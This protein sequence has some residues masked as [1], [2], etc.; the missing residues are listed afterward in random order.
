MGIFSGL[1]SKLQKSAT[2]SL[3]ADQIYE[4]LKVVIDPDLGK[5]IVTL[6]FVRNP[7]IE[8]QNV[9]VEV[10]LTTPACP[11]KEQLKTQCENALKALPGIG[12]VT[13]TMTATTREP[14]RDA[15]AKVHPALAQVKHIIA[16][17]SGKGGVGKSTSAVNLAFALA[18]TGAK[19]GILDADV[20]GPSLPKMVKITKGAQQNGEASIVPPEAHGV[21]LLSAGMFSDSGQATILRGPMAGNLLK[22][23][24]TQ[25]EWGELDY[26]L[27]DYPPGTGDIQLTISQTVSLSGA[28]IITTPQ[29]VALLDVKKAI[30]MF[31]TLK[32]PVLG[33]IETMS[34]FLCDGCDKKHFIFREGGGEKLAREFGVSYLATVPLDPKVAVSSDEGEPLVVRSPDSIVSKAYKGAAGATAQQLSILASSTSQNLGQFS[35]SWQ[36]PN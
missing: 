25:V 8:G 10:N 34:Y 13:V 27:I 5:D 15:A 12:D 9:K 16:V 22:Q 2:P 24:L 21:K 4:A 30:S 31:K 28:V 35:L 32:V 1:T 19:V 11:V 3:T 7:V 18:Q 33:V 14:K 26:L 20:Y 17:A 6:G 29:D 23:F 36:K